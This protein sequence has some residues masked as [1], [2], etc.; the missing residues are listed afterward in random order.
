MTVRAAAKGEGPLTQERVNG[1][2]PFANGIMILCHRF[3]IFVTYV[4]VMIGDFRYPRT[5]VD[6]YNDKSDIFS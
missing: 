4:T 2:F 1:P 5:V 3:Y 6:R